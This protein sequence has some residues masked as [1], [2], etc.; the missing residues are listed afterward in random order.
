MSDPERPATARGLS[1]DAPNPVNAATERDRAEAPLRIEELRE[2]IRRHDYAYY[3]LDEPQIADADYDGL[4]RELKELERRFP[5]LVTPD[6]PTQRVGGQASALFAPAPHR[7][8]M[9]SLDNVFS[10]AEL[11]GWGKRLEKAAGKDLSFVCE[12]KI[13]GLAVSLTYQRGSLVRGATRGDGSVGEDITANLRTIEQIPRRLDGP[14]WPE[15]LEI[16]GEVYMSLSRFAALNA[17]LTARGERP[18]T[19]PRNAAAGSLRQKDAAVTAA[20]GLRLWCYGV[21]APDTR[22][23]NRHSDDLERLR[24]AGFPINPAIES[25]TTL[26]EVF[27]Y[28][29][30]W[31][32][33]RHDVDY[34]IDGIVIKVDRYD[35]RDELGAT[36]KAPRWAV[37][38]K[39]PPEERTSVVRE[40]AV[41]TGRTGKVTPF[42]VLEPVFVGGA[43]VAYATL[44]NQDEVARK[45]VRQGDTVI[46]RRAGDVIPEIVGPVLASRPPEAVPWV[47]PQVCP[48]CGTTLVR[49]EG[50]ADWR[51]PNKAGC[52]SQSI[53][54]IFYFASTDAMDIVHLGYQTGIAL[55][56][57]GWVRDPADIYTL[58]AEQLAQLPGFAE[59]SVQNL[60]D[61]IAASKDR[62][63]WRLLVGLNIRRVGSRVAQL[64]AKRFGSVD[65]LA[66]ASVEDMQTV[67]GIGPEIATGVHEWFRRPENQ[68]LLE[69]LRAAGV[70]MADPA[71]PVKTAEEQPLLG[72][73]IVITGTLPTLSREAATAAA[74]AAGA[75]VSGSVSKKTSFVLAG[76]NAGTKLERATTLGVEIIDEPEFL[77]R[78]GRAPDPGNT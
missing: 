75:R 16:R 66:A 65:A 72:K 46:V 41:N 23:L 9:L 47:F 11:D 69:K 42:A 60:L 64:F 53:E 28:C 57:R 10:R 62:P 78:L 20:R 5:E 2:L 44:H 4:M 33:Q 12:L 73:T 32:K 51:C 3:V 56:E 58:T 30:R 76:E 13:D 18:L 35:Q 70:R 24:A 55:L 67:G 38:F 48:S 25:V 39:F 77:R 54:W 31:Q 37:A 34:Q 52:P 59:K 15:H 1:P 45:D 8:P 29:E 61:A 40:I 7:T 17:E 22:R 6:S 27:A 74:E 50:E 19:N 71:E 68:A 49:P 43:T 36:S 63:V 14:H 21:A 26:D